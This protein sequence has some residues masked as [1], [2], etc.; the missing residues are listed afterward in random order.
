MLSQVK[1]TMTVEMESEE[2]VRLLMTN[3][4]SVDRVEGNTQN[5]QI[6]KPPPPPPP[7]V[8]KV[9]PAGW[10]EFK[11][12]NNAFLVW[13]PESAGETTE[14]NPTIQPKKIPALRLTVTEL[15]A[16][17]KGGPIY[18]ASTLDAFPFTAIGKNTTLERIDWLRD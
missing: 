12:R 18:T 8:K 7:V 1:T 2:G 13:L 10:K 9:V 3:E 16:A 6:P 14:N 11:P 5:F 17:A 4:N 15:T